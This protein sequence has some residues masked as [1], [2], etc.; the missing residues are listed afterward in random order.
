MAY[1]LDLRERAIALLEEGKSSREVGEVLGI[2]DRTVLIWKKRHNEGRLAAHYPA[3]RRA[4]HI[5]DE[6]LQA[7]LKTHPDAYL[8]ELAEVAGGTPQGI[9]HA[10]KRLNITRKKRPRSIGKEM[11]K[12]A[13]PTLN[14]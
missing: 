2:S 11:K 14:A 13:R 9:L 6:A 7:H 1:S 12:N 8:E 10:L 4:Y 3:S 5:N